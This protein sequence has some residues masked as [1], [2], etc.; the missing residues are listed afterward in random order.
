MTTEVLTSPPAAFQLAERGDALVAELSGGWLLR[1]TLPPPE[2]F[3]AELERR[4][5][6]SLAFDSRAVTAWDSGF[7]VWLT[8]VLAACKQRSI[9]VDRSGLPQGVQK[10]LALA[11]A[12]PEKQGARGGERHASLLERIGRFALT[13]YQDGKDLLAFLGNVMLALGRLLRGKARFQRRDLMLA[14][15][16]CGAEALPIVTLISFIVGL[17][18]AFVG[19]V[20]LE[21]FGASIYV[22]NL[23]ALAMAREMAALMTGIIMSGRTGAAFAAQLGTM[24]VNEEIDALKTMGISP[25][26]FLVLPRLLALVVMLPLLSIYSNLIGMIGGGVVATSMLGLNPALYINQTI[27]AVSITDFATGIFKAG[28]FGV[29]VAVAGCLRGL[30]TG[31]GASAVGEAATRAVV[32]GIVAIVCADGVFAVLFNVM[33]I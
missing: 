23:V 11:E 20:Q 4:T 33:G 22:A 9:A 31:S 25:L 24:K 32:T 8:D 3:V 6:R 19:A 27:D 1:E 18:L 10:L 14:I 16:Q 15:Q 28:V 17:I 5:P 12:V 13:I 29:L 30:Q 2:G 26:D 21:Q 7:L